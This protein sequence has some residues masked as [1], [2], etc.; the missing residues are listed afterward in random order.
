MFRIFMLVA[1]I[2][3]MIAA[4]RPRIL[5]H[6]MD[7]IRYTLTNGGHDFPIVP[8]VS[9][10][11]SLYKYLDAQYYGLITIGTPPQEFKVI[12]DTDSS[13]LWISSEKC[14][15]H[16]IGCIFPNK[17]DSKKSC[18]YIQNG[19][20]IK[21]PCGGNSMTGILSTDVVNIAGFNV[22]NQTFAE[23]MHDQSEAFMYAKFDGMMGM[24]FN[25]SYINEVIPVFHNLVKRR[26]MSSA[27]FSFYLNKD[28]S[29]KVGGALILGGADPNY[30][31]GN[32][33]YVPVSKKGSWQFTIDKIT[34]HR[35]ILDEKGYPAIHEHILCPNGCQAIVNPGTSSIYGPTSDVSI[36][37]QLLGTVYYYKK[38][39]HRTFCTTENSDNIPVINFIIGGKMFDLTSQDYLLQVSR[40]DNTTC[41]SGFI[42]HS[43]TSWILGDIFIRRYYSVFNFEKGRM[44]F[45]PA[46]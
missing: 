17:Y 3:V 4:Q 29:A 26:L 24:R 42:R 7:S 9:S 39:E 2:L 37:N 11:V 44:G 18:T 30:Y 32:L 43:T 22:Q 1:T 19:T 23:A 21:I 38:G 10:K 25:M 27:I 15:L 35:H 6:K 34:I 31:V 28:L 8:I 45:V 41:R 33:T 14:I 16:N 36:I 12:F 46:R 20:A 5:L 40:N 13:N